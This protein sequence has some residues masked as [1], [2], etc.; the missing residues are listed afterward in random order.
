MLSFEKEKKS[1]VGDGHPDSNFANELDVLYK[2][3]K[4][5]LCLKKNTF[6]TIKSK[7]WLECVYN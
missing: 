2:N 3:I 7:Y 1:T 6:K 5:A 4:I